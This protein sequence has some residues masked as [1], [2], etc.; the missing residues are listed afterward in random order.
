[1]AVVIAVAELIHVF[2]QM[3]RRD[4]NVR[5]ADAVLEVRPKALN[6]VGAEFAT[7]PF[8]DFVA[9]RP[10]R[11]AV[12]VEFLVSGQRVGADGRAESHILEDMR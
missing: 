1:M 10:M 9:N 12:L 3:L 7:D 6:P 8:V 5:A 4:M 2:L 11:V